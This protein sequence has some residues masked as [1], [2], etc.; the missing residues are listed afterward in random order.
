MS[1]PD[2]IRSHVQFTGVCETT[3]SKH[4]GG[5]LQDPHHF[6]PIGRVDAEPTMDAMVKV[7]DVSR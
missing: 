5:V 1:Q 3:V 2:G 6:L 4:V 7:D